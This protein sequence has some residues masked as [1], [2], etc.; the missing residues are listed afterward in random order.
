MSSL[1]NLPS[2]VCGGSAKT[3]V[4]DCSQSKIK[5]KAEK[6]VKH[7]LGNDQAYDGIH[8]GLYAVSCKTTTKVG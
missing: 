6:G 1:A 4:Q 5:Y 7:S 8:L 3:A 2:R